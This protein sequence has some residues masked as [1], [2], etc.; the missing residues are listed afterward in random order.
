VSPQGVARVPTDFYSGFG[1]VVP[2]KNCALK[3]YDWVLEKKT[4]AISC[5]RNFILT[6]PNS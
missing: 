3:K 2:Q 1:P 4:N 5:R 6:S